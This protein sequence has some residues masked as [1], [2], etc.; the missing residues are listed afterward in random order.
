M[1]HNRTFLGIGWKFPPEFDK[2]RKT[3]TLVSEEKDIEESLFILLSTR[4]GE[5]IMQPEYGCNLNVINFEPINSDFKDN[6]ESIIRYAVLNFEP[7]ISIVNIDIST[8]EYIDGIINIII[9]YTI[10]KT[11]SRSNIVYPYYIIEG[12]EITDMP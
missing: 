2:K 10:I 12:T 7:R 4:T 5:R 6:V 1:N 8:E 3:V 11:N 9:E